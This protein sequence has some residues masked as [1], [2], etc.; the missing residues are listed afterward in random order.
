MAQ[1]SAIEIEGWTRTG[2][3]VVV[4]ETAN[5][6]DDARKILE[7]PARMGLLPERPEKPDK[8]DY[9]RISHIALSH[10]EDGTPHVAFFH[11]NEKL[12]S[13]WTH[14]Y[15]N[16]FEERLAFEK[17]AG[18]SLDGQPAMDGNTHPVR[19][20]AAAARFLIALSS[21]RALIRLTTFEKV[22]ENGQDVWQPSHDVERYIGTDTKSNKSEQPAVKWY[23]DPAQMMMVD[24]WVAK[25][26]EA[27]P[28]FYIA[29]VGEIGK[30]ESFPTP[31]AY[32]EALKAI[33]FKKENEAQGEDI[34]F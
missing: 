25:A 7:M 8:T 17:W 30:R 3:R 27:K 31:A 12:E 33:A 21:P 26:K 4:R 28:D 9:G 34:P 22:T 2:F 18:I 14:K 15:L 19:G 6:A 10:T 24:A 20:K 32:I 29:A 23:E 13:R 5:N 11:E 16:S 1:Q